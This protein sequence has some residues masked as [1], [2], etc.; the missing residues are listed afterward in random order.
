MPQTAVR[1]AGE[2]ITTKD[3][4]P[5][6][7]PYTREAFA[8]VPLCGAD[9]VKRAC[10]AAAEALRRDDFPLYRRAEVLTSAAAL[11]RERAD[12]FAQSITRE[13]GKTIDA[14][15]GETARCVDTFAFAAV[16]ARRLAGEMVAMEASAAGAGKLGFAIRVPLG[17]VAAITPFNFPLNLVAHKLAPAIAAGC[18]VVLKPAPQTPLTAIR[19]VELLIEAGLPEDWISVVTDAGKEAA[20][21]LVEHAIPKMITFTGSAP[22]GWMIAAKAPKKRVVLELGSNSPVIFEPDTELEAIMP[23]LKTAAFGVAGQSCISVQRVLVH[24]SLHDEFLEKVKALAESLVCGDPM[25]EKTDIGPLIRAA[26]NVRIEEWIEEAVTAGAQVIT[27]G[28]TKDNLFPATVVDDVPGDVRLSCQEVF[29][30]V[31]AVH[32]YGSFDEA[33]E[34]ANRSAFGLHCGVFT[35]DVGKALKAIKRLDFGGV[36]INEM[37]TYRAD[38]QPYGGIGESGNTRE[39]PAYTIKEMTEL[40]FVSLQPP[41]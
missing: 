9:E 21:P 26:D 17:V 31:I 23:R 19:L 14:A 11:I 27:G 8:A 2:R 37:P 3:S 33:I 12:E 30:P 15:R 7:N 4:V 13:S 22:V 1:I 25:D 36:L 38:Q 20:E 40:R 18:P 41:A 29:G 28:K 10:H 39:G 35:H 16:E 6:E 34:L 32:T 24:E 5:V